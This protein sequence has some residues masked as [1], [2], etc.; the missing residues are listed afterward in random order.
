MI[1]FGI[2]TSPALFAA[3]EVTTWIM[4]KT[5]I[6]SYRTVQ[7]V[8]ATVSLLVILRGAGLGIPFISPAAAMNGKVVNCC[9]K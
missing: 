9:H 1:L 5:R 6:R 3:A 8:L 7:I 4:K 2:A